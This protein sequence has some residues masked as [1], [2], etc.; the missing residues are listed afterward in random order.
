M[1]NGLS[2]IKTIAGLVLGIILISS[3]CYEANEYSRWNVFETKQRDVDFG[4]VAFGPQPFP[5]SDYDRILDSN[6]VTHHITYAFNYVKGVV[7]FNTYNSSKNCGLIA[8]V[9]KRQL[10]SNITDEYVIIITSHKSTNDI[11]PVGSLITLYNNGIDWQTYKSDNG[12]VMNYIETDT[13]IVKTGNVSAD[14]PTFIGFLYLY[15][16]FRDH[17]LFDTWLLIYIYW[18]ILMPILWD[19]G[20]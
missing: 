11:C 2:T 17:E 8:V 1:S 15:I 4:T 19:I 5:V 3:I 6:N 13:G 9:G 20:D 16:L 7:I 10:E 12:T 14:D 18:F